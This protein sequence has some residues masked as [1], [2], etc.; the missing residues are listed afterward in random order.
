MP[1]LII[2]TE[3]RWFAQKT[4]NFIVP[5]SHLY[6]AVLSIRYGDLRYCWPLLWIYPD[7]I[8]VS[9]ASLINQYRNHFFPALLIA[10]YSQSRCSY[11]RLNWARLL[12]PIALNRSEMKQPKSQMWEHV[13][14][15]LLFHLNLRLSFGE[16]HQFHCHCKFVGRTLSLY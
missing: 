15:F 9:Q 8:T 14:N 7:Y 13:H 16:Q 3:S 5:S 2:T 4:I 1:D 10:N 11:S 12:L 6:K